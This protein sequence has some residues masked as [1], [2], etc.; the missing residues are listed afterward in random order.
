M[1]W[2]FAQFVYLA[3]TS[4][5]G[6]TYPS[7]QYN[8]AVISETQCSSGLSTLVFFTKTATNANQLLYLQSAP[9]DLPCS[10]N[11]FFLGLSVQ[12]VGNG[13][14]WTVISTV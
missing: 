3:H 2:I 6:G 7:L 14:L 12:L 9:K 13:Q 8:P 10:P 11:A 5:A 1:S 4:A